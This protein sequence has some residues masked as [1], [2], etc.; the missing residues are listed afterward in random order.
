MKKTETDRLS[1]AIND[2]AKRADGKPAA[3]APA[4]PP[5]DMT[6]AQARR[7]ELA[8]LEQEDYRVRAEAATKEIEQVLRKYGLALKT[9]YD[10]SP[11]PP[12]A[13]V[14]VNAK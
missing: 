7:E 3:P 9:T 8:R 1:K 2:A 14:L 6:A 4:E 11:V 13:P 10:L 12:P 5:P